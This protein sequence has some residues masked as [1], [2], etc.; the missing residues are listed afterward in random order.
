M[1]DRQ[2][3]AVSEVPQRKPNTPSRLDYHTLTLPLNAPLRCGEEEKGG[4]R[5]R[6]ETEKKKKQGLSGYFKLCCRSIASN[7]LVCWIYSL[8]GRSQGDRRDRIVAKSLQ[9]GTNLVAADLSKSCLLT[10]DT[11]GIRNTKKY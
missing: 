9:N 8:L 3:V 10:D 4:G 11:D 7:R 1:A 2:A 6:R 5:G